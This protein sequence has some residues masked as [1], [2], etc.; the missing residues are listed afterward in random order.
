MATNNGRSGHG[1]RGGTLSD[2]H[3]IL[4]ER[5]EALAD[6]SLEGEDLDTEIKRCSAITDVADTAIR[7]AGTMLKAAEQRYAMGM[8]SKDQADEIPLLPDGS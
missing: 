1:R 5:I 2:L 6:E 7:N 3:G 8:L 4:M